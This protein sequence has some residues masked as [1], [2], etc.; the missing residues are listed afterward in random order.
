[1][2]QNISVIPNSKTITLLLIKE[3]HKNLSEMCVN[4]KKISY[5]WLAAR[6]YLNYCSSFTI[7][8]KGEFRTVFN[9]QTFAL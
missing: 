5:Y 6:L 3:Y 8:D 9:K 4:F 1:M 7:N 2:H